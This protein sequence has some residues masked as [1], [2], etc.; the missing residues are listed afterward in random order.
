MLALR[1]PRKDD[2]VAGGRDNQS[3]GNG[4]LRDAQE[5]WWGN[6]RK[7]EIIGDKEEVEPGILRG[8]SEYRGKEGEGEEKA[9]STSLQPDRRIPGLKDFRRIA[10]RP[11]I[12]HK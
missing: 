6:N 9:R 11:A 5:A 7:Q 12:N 8:G 1:V 2:M 4:E 10:S 3:Q